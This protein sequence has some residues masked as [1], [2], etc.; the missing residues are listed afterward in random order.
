MI[1]ISAK[2]QHNFEPQVWLSNL[3]AMRAHDNPKL[4][5]EALALAQIAS[6]E[7][8]TPTGQSP[9][10]LG[11]ETCEVL[12]N[13]NLDS[14]S[15]AAAIVFS[16][17]QYADLLLEDVKEH[18]GPT[19]AKLVQGTL[20]MDAIS[21]FYRAI[22]GREQYRQ[23]LDNIR[24]MFLAMVD[25]IRVVLIKLAERLCMLRG[26]KGLSEQF[27]YALASETMAIYSPLAHRLGIAQI[28]WELEDLSFGYLEAAKYQEILSKLNSAF[29]ERQAY[30]KQVVV[31]LEQVLSAS[32]LKNFKVTGRAK[33]VYSVYSKMQRK[34]VGVESIFDV[35][36][37]RIFMP[38]I[39][40]CYTALSHVHEKWKY[41]PQEFDDYIAAPKPNGYRSIHTAVYGPLNHIVEIQIRT[42]DMHQEAELGIAAHWI[43]KEGARQAVSYESK[44]AWL[45]EVLDWQ[46]EVTKSTDVLNEIRQVFSDTV[47]VFTPQGDIV[48]LAQGSTPLDFAY[49]IHS[50]VG[51]R[52]I[53]A[54]VNGS[55]V[56]LVYNLKTGDRVEILTAKNATPSRDWL[57]PNLGFLK[58]TRARSKVLSWF[59][60]L[61]L[62]K[63]LPLTEAQT[64]E[65]KETEPKLIPIQT[66]LAKQDTIATEIAVCGVD[67]LLTRIAQCCKPIFGEKII[68]YITQT[69]G[70]SVHRANCANIIHA[71]QVKPERLVDISWGSTGAK[72][73]AVSLLVEASDRPGLVRD[74]TNV[75]AEAG[76]TIAGLE[77][78]TDSKD[79]SAIINMTVEVGS[80]GSLDKILAK[81]KQV[82]CVVEVRRV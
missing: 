23:N 38:N 3:L 19:V 72:R 64:V 75:L 79:N 51:H 39:T 80:V 50:D 67:N 8:A 16:S 42:Y 12:N 27:K 71:K 55:I 53:G 2:H 44:I 17:V 25:D 56:P 54:K 70:I 13:L 24:K 63:A 40:D 65:V 34:K 58:T 52:C 4:I 11:C 26:A 48:D 45:R 60:K 82:P 61:D 14:T 49:H 76:V 37:V 74:V 20:Q 36:A 10:A 59:R 57:N 35:C 32:G 81:I 30:I 77:L 69:Q 66:K 15:L 43:Y 47:Y 9:L 46:Q 7:M 62:E 6:Q 18:L 21:E 31:E 68:G 22:K 1:S 33:H 41:I 5:A 29:P 73:Y 78:K 28:K